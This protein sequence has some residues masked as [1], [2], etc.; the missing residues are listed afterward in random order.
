LGFALFAP[1]IS[2]GTASGSANEKITD[3]KDKAL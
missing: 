2:L 1:K 3:R